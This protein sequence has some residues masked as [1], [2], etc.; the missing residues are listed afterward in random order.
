MLPSGFCSTVM[1]LG[2]P[3]WIA[4][5]P[6]EVVVTDTSASFAAS[7]V[8]ETPPSPSLRLSHAGRY[9]HRSPPSLRRPR[10]ASGSPPGAARAI[11]HRP[12]RLEP[13]ACAT[14]P[15]RA[16]PRHVARRLRR[17]GVET[18][19][20]C[21]CALG[22]ALTSLFFLYPARARPAL[23][24]DPSYARQQPL[25]LVSG[26]VPRGE[27]VRDLGAR[28][29]AHDREFAGNRWCDGR[30]GAR[31]RDR[32]WPVER[33]EAVRRA[34]AERYLDIAGRRCRD[35]TGTA[36]ATRRARSATRS[37]ALDGNVC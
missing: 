32:A 7:C 17:G 25:V 12:H 13:V 29:D 10:A 24:G 15:K 27:R 5:F 30:D 34:V 22:S 21:R 19:T 36:R 8:A 18:P 28:R 26:Q 1:L 9:R 11:E 20:A 4:T 23:N 31:D 6:G 14:S 2:P 16:C 35:S 33:T 37:E 3:V